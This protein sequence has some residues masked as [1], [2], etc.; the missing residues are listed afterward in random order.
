MNKIL[1]QINMVKQQLRTN[2]INSEKVLNLY[3]DIPRSD[4][5]P[6]AYQAFAYTDMQIPLS[7]HQRMLT[8]LE[9]A[10]ILQALQLEGHETVLE[11]GTGTGFFTTLLSHLAKYIIT[12]D[13]FSEFTQQA[14]KSCQAHGRNNIE[15][16]TDDAHNGWVHKAPY[17]VIVL[18][19]A[20]SK[21]TD[22]L[23]LQL[24]I[25]G[26]LFA[27]TGKHPVVTGYLYRLDHQN[28]WS[29][30]LVFETDIPML[31]DKTQH[32]SFVF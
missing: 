16:V 4:F 27:I 22:M 9:E 23:K 25:G 29:K 10:Q 28:S 15:F 8:P 19:G 6:Q 3:H 18:T 20:I 2:G 26:K 7:H 21:V 12:V 30:T 1:A 32:S 14:Q 17:D 11:I 5:V 24:S 13:Y 31:I